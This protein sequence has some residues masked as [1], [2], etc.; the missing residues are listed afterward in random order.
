[1]VLVAHLAASSAVLAQVYA[2]KPVRIVVVW[3]PGDY[4]V[5][6]NAATHVANPHK[7]WL[8]TRM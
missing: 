6:V 7:N 5:M 2:A 3:L 4:T 1:L 8:M